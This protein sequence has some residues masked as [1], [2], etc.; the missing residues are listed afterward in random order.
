MVL[1]A[2]MP[3]M[4]GIRVF[5]DIRK[6]APEVRILFVSGYTREIVARDILQRNATGFLQ[7]PFDAE[8]LVTALW[9]LL[10]DGD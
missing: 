7:K 6:I 5:E 1:D 4:S 8:Q 9:R 3:G 10:E 2:T